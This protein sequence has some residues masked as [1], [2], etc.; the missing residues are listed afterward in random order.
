[1]PAKYRTSYAV[2]FFLVISAFSFTLPARAYQ[3]NVESQCCS[4]VT[5]A[6]EAAN[7]IKKGMSRAEIEKEFNKDGG[8]DFGSS[9]IYTFKLCSLIKIRVEFVQ[10]KDDAASANDHQKDLVQSVSKPYI[11]YPMRD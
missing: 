4:M 9:T 3:S 11:E 1:M 2:S 10:N 8:I 5:Q 6:L 7:R